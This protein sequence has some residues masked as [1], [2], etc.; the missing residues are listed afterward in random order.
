MWYFPLL[1]PF[2]D[3]VPVKA[4]LSDLAEQINGVEITMTNVDALQPV[5]VK[6]MLLIFPKKLF[7]ITWNCCVGTWGPDMSLPL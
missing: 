2:E 7:E 1:K 5:Q 4:D 3:H 6:F